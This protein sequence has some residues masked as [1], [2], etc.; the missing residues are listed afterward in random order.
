M[1][2]TLEFYFDFGSPNAYLCH[3]A[4][5]PLIARTGATLVYKPALLGGI[6]KATNNQPPMMAFKDIKGKMAYEQTE[7][8]RFVRKHDLAKFTFNSHFPV[9]TLLLMRGAMAAKRDGTLPTYIDA[10]L[11]AMW[12]EDR[13][14]SE[15]EVFAATF[16]ASGLDGE[17]LLSDTQD[18]DIKAALVKATEDAVARGFFGIPTFFVGDEM[19]FGKERLSQIEEELNA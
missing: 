18:P 4:L 19:F 8:V 2:K 16:T 5:K 10:G 14:M 12:E 11:A 1:T 6:F 7:F 3:H 9:N 13:N 15:P 17:K